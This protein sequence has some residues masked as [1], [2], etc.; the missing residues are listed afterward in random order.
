MA[1]HIIVTFTPLDRE[2]LKAYSQAAG[3]TVAAFDGEFIN[4]GPLRVLSGDTPHQM[5]AIIQFPSRAQAEAWYASDDYQALLPLRDKG[6]D[7]VFTV[8]GE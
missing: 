3:P 4:R 8:V 6:M 5:H 1:A 7:A 2:Q